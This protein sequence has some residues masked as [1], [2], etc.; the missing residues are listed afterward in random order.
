MATQT[1]LACDGCG[2]TA[3]ADHIAR[4]LKRLEEAT[5]FRPIHIQTLFLGAIMPMREE[6]YLYARSQEGFQGESAEVLKKAGIDTGRMP[7]ETVLAE[8]QRGG[9]FLAHVLPCPSEG[10]TEGRRLEFLLQK[11]MPA[12]L[13]RLKRSLRPKRVVL[14]S[15]ELMAVAGILEKSLPEIEWG[16]EDTPAAI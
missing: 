8:F 2:Q 9:Y 3:S 7:R 1:L 4:R 16:R 15:P 6:E 13:I 5:R 10:E 12:L 11:Q 14:L